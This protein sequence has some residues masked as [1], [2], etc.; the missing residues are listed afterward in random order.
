MKTLI[1]KAGVE[2][3]QILCLPEGW[4]TNNT[5]NWYAKK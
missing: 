1:D 2:K 3:C 5:W 4:A